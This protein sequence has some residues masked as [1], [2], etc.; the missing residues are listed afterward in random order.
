VKAPQTF[1]QHDPEPMNMVQDTP[2]LAM[3]GS[4]C[5]VGC[6]NDIAFQKMFAASFLLTA[7]SMMLMECQISGVC[8]SIAS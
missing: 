2:A 3:L 8:V 5:G 7:L 1:V 6:Q 4:D